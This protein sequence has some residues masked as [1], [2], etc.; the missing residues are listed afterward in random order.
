MSQVEKKTHTVIRCKHK[1]IKY[2]IEYKIFVR[3]TFHNHNKTQ[4]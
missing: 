3:Q 2:N 1:N 4:P